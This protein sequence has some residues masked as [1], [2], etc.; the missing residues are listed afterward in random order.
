MACALAGFGGGGRAV[1]AEEIFREF[2][3]LFR[4]GG[5]PRGPPRGRD[6]QAQLEL[7]FMEA[8][9]GCRKKISW[10]S[11][12]DGLREVEAH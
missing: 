4:G 1:D 9:G 8:V 11:P 2:E 7:D 6:V 12:S 3:N 5:R 10:R